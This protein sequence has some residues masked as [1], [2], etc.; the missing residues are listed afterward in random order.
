MP[1]AAAIARYLEG[2]REPEDEALRAARARAEEAD[3]APMGPEVGAALRWFARL[4]GARQMVEVG[5]GGGAS[6]LWLLGGADPRATLT[7]I[8]PDPEVRQLALRAYADAGVADRVRSIEG[9]ATTVLPRLADGGYDLI[10]LDADP[11]EYPDLREHVV[12][13]LRP[14]GL[15]LVDDPL[16][17]GRVADE[18]SEDPAVL[19]LRR[20]HAELAEEPSL[21][22]HVAPG[23][24][25]LLAAVREPG[26]A[27]EH[28]TA[29]A[30]GAR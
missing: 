14:G 20:F 15:L 17:G 26:R 8:E 10:L 18:A 28:P 3:L 1:A 16:A 29:R 12:R 21:R 19:G 9:T 5:S 13:M 24:T 22:P 4:I 25:A 27:S 2:L 7:S 23:S 6:G 30:S 11:A